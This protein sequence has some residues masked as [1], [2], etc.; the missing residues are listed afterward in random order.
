[1]NTPG[2]LA[3]WDFSHCSFKSYFVTNKIQ[4]AQQTHQYPTNKTDHHLLKKYG[5]K[6][7]ACQNS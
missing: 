2:L 5:T 4:I 1:M 3:Q 7:T 6:Q